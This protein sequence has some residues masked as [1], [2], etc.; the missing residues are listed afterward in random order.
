MS[1]PSAGP[2]V[3][4]GEQSDHPQVLNGLFTVHHVDEFDAAT[5]YNENAVFRIALVVDNFTGGQMPL[6][7]KRD[8]VRDL[9]RIQRGEHSI[10][11]FNILRHE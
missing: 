7:A 2:G 5:Q 9:R 8:Q 10:R 6:F 1:S 11:E 4:F 3:C